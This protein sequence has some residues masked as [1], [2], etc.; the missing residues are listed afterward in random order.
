MALKKCKECK[1][2]ISSKAKICPQCGYK[3]KSFSTELM[4][5][6]CA[7]TILSP[8]LILLLMGC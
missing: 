1:A 8:L 6:G 7:I 5:T 4:K 2:E 3:K